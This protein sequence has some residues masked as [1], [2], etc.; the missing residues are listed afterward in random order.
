MWGVH[1]SSAATF[2]AQVTHDTKTLGRKDRLLVSMAACHSLTII[3]GTIS[4]DP[5]DYKMFEATG[6][7]RYGYHRI[8]GAPFPV[9]SIPV[10][11]PLHLVNAF[12][13]MVLVSLMCNETHFSFIYI[14]LVIYIYFFIYLFI[15]W[16]VLSKIIL[17]VC[18][19]KYFIRPHPNLYPLFHWTSQTSF[20]LCYIDCSILCLT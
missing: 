12:Y 10:K 3:E 13:E 8:L 1:P 16:N 14:Y 15:F 11:E 2:S 4:G 9:H 6:W 19:T 7:V 18:F 17:Q 20:A 5:L